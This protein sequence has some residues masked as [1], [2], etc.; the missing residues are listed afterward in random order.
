MSHFKILQQTLFMGAYV[1]GQLC[2]MLWKRPKISPGILPG[3]CLFIANNLLPE[4]SSVCVK[5][6]NSCTSLSCLLR[7]RHYKV[8]VASAF[9]DL[10]PLMYW[11]VWRIY[12]ACCLSYLFLVSTFSLLVISILIFSMLP[13]SERGIIIYLLIFNL[14]NTCTIRSHP[15]YL[16]LPLH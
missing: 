11:N 6:E 7:Y 13:A 4:H 8:A 1:S 15:E 16:D 5:I 10:P 12:M 9:I 2:R 14:F 3:S